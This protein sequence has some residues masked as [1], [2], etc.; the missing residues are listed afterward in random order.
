MAESYLKK[1]LKKQLPCAAF[2]NGEYNTKNLYVGVPVI[3]GSKGVE[4]VIEL[5]LTKDEQMNFK[6]SIDAVKELLNAAKKLIL[7]LA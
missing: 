3:I 6:K 2:L 4:K 7:A 5:S 1:D